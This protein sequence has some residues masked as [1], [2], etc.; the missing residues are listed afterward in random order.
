M[1]NVSAD[2]FG[3][4]I[5]YLLPGLT[6]LWGLGYVSP[7][8][9]SW[10]G[11]TSTSPPTIGGFLY[12]TLASVAAGLIVST[13]RWAVLDTI[14]HWTG[15][16]RPNWDFAR[17][18]ENVTAFDVLIEIHYRYYQHYGNMLVSLAFAYAARRSALGLWSAPLGWLDLG[19]LLLALVFFFGSRDT[20]RKYYQ[21]T[22]RF[23]E[24]ETENR[25]DTPHDVGEPP[26]PSSP[27]GDETSPQPPS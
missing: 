3:L 6:V 16:R 24:N 25:E 12:V 7:T 2:N 8:M 18:Q 17:L 27:A 23:L 11:T 14:H 15:I 22:A 4:L 9:R 13:V 20:L 19:L 26:K 1:K 5:A 10:L 21:R